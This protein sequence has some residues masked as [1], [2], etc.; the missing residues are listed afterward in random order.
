MSQGCM[1]YLGAIEA[2]SHTAK[3]GAR[4]FSGGLYR[5]EHTLRFRE[6]RA[7]IDCHDAIFGIDV[8][9]KQILDVDTS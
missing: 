3:V 8:R 9:I 4:E 5:L 7:T 6:R 1:S 2:G